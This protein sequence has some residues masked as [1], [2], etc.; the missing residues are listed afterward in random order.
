MLVFPTDWSPRNTWS[1]QLSNANQISLLPLVARL[2]DC[3]LTSLY[4]ASGE[5]VEVAIEGSTRMQQS[6]IEALWLVTWLI[7]SGLATTKPQAL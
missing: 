2:G 5:T 6:L 1:K 7:D 4:F 3:E